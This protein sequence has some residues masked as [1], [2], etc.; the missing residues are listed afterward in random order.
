MPKARSGNF[1]LT[2]IDTKLT[3]ERATPRFTA[4]QRSGQYSELRFI[5]RGKLFDIVGYKWPSKTTRRKL[6]IG[7]ARKNPT[8]LPTGTELYNINQSAFGVITAKKTTGGKVSYKIRDVETG[9]EYGAYDYEIGRTYEPDGID[10]RITTAKSYLQWRKNMIKQWTAS[11]KKNP[12]PSGDATP[13]QVIF[14]QYGK[15]KVGWIN[16]E[17]KTQYQLTYKQ[18]AQTRTVWRKKNLITFQLTDKKGKI[19]NNCPK[20]ANPRNGEL[21]KAIDLSKKFHG[22]HPTAISH[23]DIRLPKA[24]MQ[25]G[26]CAQVDYISDKY[27][28]KL[29]QYFHRFEKPCLVFA[30]VNPQRDGDHILI[31]KGQFE[32]TEDGIIG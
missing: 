10:H 22:F 29:R 31:I 5:Q 15:K 17:T 21:V 30:T 3:A 8:T 16:R 32:I 9:H 14:S 23:I 25:I 6:N 18:G 19:K 1:T 27:D 4:L 26:A 12:T 20:T 11:R 28:N 7:R 13:N 24:I 2:K